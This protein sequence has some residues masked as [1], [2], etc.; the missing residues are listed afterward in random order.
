MYQRRPWEGM[1]AGEAHLSANAGYP[2]VSQ[3]PENAEGRRRTDA[4]LESPG[5]YAIALSTSGLN[6]YPDPAPGSPATG[7]VRKN[8]PSAMRAW[9]IPAIS[10]A[11]G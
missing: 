10:L 8:R 5:T 1:A 2:A 9:S 11:L 7:S 3:P 6:A 4:A